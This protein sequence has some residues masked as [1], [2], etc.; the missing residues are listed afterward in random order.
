M[1]TT[2][3]KKAAKAKYT[4][5]IYESAQDGWFWRCRHRNGHIVADGAEGYASKAKLRRALKNLLGAIHDVD[6]FEIIEL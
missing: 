2:K 4:F 3:P 6:D 1:K 5:I